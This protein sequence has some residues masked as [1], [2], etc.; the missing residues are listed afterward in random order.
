MKR[1]FYLACLAACALVASCA[2][3]APSG[4]ISQEPFEPAELSITPD[5]L[6]IGGGAGAQATSTITTDSEILSFSVKDAAVRWLDAEIDGTSLKMITKTVNTTGAERTGI[7]TVAAG[8]GINTT[9][10]NVVVTQEVGVLDVTP[11]IAVDKTEVALEGDANASAR[12]VITSNV[13]GVTAS[14]PATVTWL[15]ALLQGS[16]LTITAI[17]ANTTGAERTATVTVTAEAS[18]KTAIATVTV[19]QAAK[20]VDP[21]PDPEPKPEPNPI[22][23][24]WQIGSPYQG[25]IL[26]W[27]SEDGATGKVLYPYSEEL[28]WG[29]KWVV[30]G[31]EKHIAIEGAFDHDNGKVNVEAMKAKDPTLA[32]FPA[33]KYCDDLEGD[34]YMPAFNE[35]KVLFEVYNGTTWDER[36]EATPDKITDAEKAARARFDNYI[37]SVYPDGVKLNRQ[38]ETD[39]GDATWSSNQRDNEPDKRVYRLRW[40][41]AADTGGTSYKHSTSKSLARC[42]KVVSAPAT[43]Q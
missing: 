18:G 12:V 41:K 25:G 1:I 40:G 37:L 21:E 33:A 11:E 22:V 30:D 2:E 31:E 32:M 17:E 27:I 15:T 9:M 14:V 19:T 16:N 10:V 7:I 23:D 34:W 8:E 29:L 24:A 28:A 39:N 26:Y 6:K 13:D 38:K 20:A 36:T 5:T 3:N 35:L 4:T 43:Q 42:I